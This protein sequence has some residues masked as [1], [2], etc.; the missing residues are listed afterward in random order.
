M[1]P[2]VNARALVLL[3]SPLLS[4]AQSTLII[5]L[6]SIIH[7]LLRVVSC[8]VLSCMHVCACLAQSGFVLRSWEGAASMSAV[9][10]GWLSISLLRGILLSTARARI[11]LDA[12][13]TL[14]VVAGGARVSVCCLRMHLVLI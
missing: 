7:L 1:C 11:G 4:P 2:P 3:C 13:S 5:S 12:P 9:L 8:R 10:E 14:P 6:S